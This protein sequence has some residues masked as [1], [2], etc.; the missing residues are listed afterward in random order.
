M[1]PKLIGGMPFTDVV[2]LHSSSAVVCS[3]D[4][5]EGLITTET[6]VPRRLHAFG[7][8][9]APSDPQQDGPTG[10]G[11]GD[12]LAKTGIASPLT[13]FDNVSRGEQ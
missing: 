11:G 9:P 5:S 12:P 7:P 6:H 4:R 10:G 2:G 8:P 1:V 13:H 3:D